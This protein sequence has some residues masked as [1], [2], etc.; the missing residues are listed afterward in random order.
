[1]VPLALPQI[2]ELARN[3]SMAKATRLTEAG[4]ARMTA[5]PPGERIDRTDLLA[6]GLYLRI[7]E[8]GRKSWMVHFRVNGRQG[9]LALGTWPTMK[10]DEARQ[11]AR[12][13]RDHARSGK[14]PRDARKEEEL[15][16]KRSSGE[17]FETIARQYVE[18]AKQGKLLGARKWPITVETALERES[19][20]NRLILPSLGHRPIYELSTIE[21]SELL[22]KIESS[23]G[24]V[25]RCLQ[26][27]IEQHVDILHQRI[28]LP[29]TVAKHL[30]E[31]E[32]VPSLCAEEFCKRLH[33]LPRLGLL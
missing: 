3:T 33:V 9:K 23:G 11:L 25:D 1:M 4:I 18:A 22:A 29:E 17:S 20:L 14:H 10:V 26:D 15:E 7:S 21:I 2:A 27:Q 31:E 12:W 24:P 16:R 8:K 19:R 5:A 6:P 30:T 13:A 32:L 28:V